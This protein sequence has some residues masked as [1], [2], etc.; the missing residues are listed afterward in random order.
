MIDPRP[1]A[2]ERARMWAA[3]LPDGELSQF[4][5][6]IL[7]V[8][9]A[10]CADC[11]SHASQ[12]A[13]IVAVVRDTPSESMRSPVEV[14]GR[15][16]LGWGHVKRFAIGSG[17]AAAVAVIAVVA[18]SLAQRA[19]QQVQQAPTLIIATPTSD[20]DEATLWR[21]SREAARNASLRPMSTRSRGPVFT[22]G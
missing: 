8:H 10:R 19:P 16:R 5:R 11:A 18:T 21:N 4:E 9:L 1:I 3:L 6:R 12:L 22:M 13:A 2:C 15:P 7:E 20:G 14:V 17:A